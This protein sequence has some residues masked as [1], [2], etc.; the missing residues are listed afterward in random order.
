MIQSLDCPPHSATALLHQ[1]AHGFPL[2]QR[3]PDGL[4]ADEVIRHGRDRWQDAGDGLVTVSDPDFLTGRDPAEDIGPL[5]RK[6]LNGGGFDDL[7]D[8]GT[9]VNLKRK[10]DWDAS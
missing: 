1:S 4:G 3:A 6:I 8:T 7:K 9:A 5:H 10:I 2:G